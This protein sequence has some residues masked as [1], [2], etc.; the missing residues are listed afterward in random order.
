MLGTVPAAAAEIRLASS[1]DDSKSAV[2][3]Y[4]SHIHAAPAHTHKRTRGHTYTA[5]S[6]GRPGLPED[7]RY[8]KEAVTRTAWHGRAQVQPNKRK[9]SANGFVW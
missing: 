7:A 1:N 9:E 5:P 8:P 6:S 3:V 2:L 4:F